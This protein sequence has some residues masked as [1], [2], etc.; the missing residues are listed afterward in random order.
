MSPL[1]TLCDLGISYDLSSR[2]QAMAEIPEEEFE[3]G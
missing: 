3:G 2:A 1:P